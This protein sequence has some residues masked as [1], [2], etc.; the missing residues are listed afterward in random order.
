MGPLWGAPESAPCPVE[1]REWLA[2]VMCGARDQ[3]APLITIAIEDIY[4]V[5]SALHLVR[6]SFSQSHDLCHLS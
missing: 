6:A 1:L 3:I 2:D 5:S 4:R